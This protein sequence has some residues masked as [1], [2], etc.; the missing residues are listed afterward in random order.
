VCVSVKNHDEYVET[1]NSCENKKEDKI[2]VVVGTDTIP[3]LSCTNTHTH[4]PTHMLE[5]DIERMAS[6]FAVLSFV[7]H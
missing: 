1:A 3:N 2:P 4:T 6:I 7:E 5:F